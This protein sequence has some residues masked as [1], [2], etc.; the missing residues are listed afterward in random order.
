MNLT[1]EEILKVKS[2]GTLN[3]IEG[4]PLHKAVI[5]AMRYYAKQEV[6]AGQHE[7]IVKRPT[8]IKDR[9]GRMIYFG[10]T[11]RFVDKVE[12]YR[13]DYWAKVAHGVMTREEAL[14]EIDEKPYEER[15]VE[16]VQDYDWLLSSEIQT[17][18]EVVGA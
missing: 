2:K 14:K 6:E 8:D 11:V 1:P 7:T 3:I 16:N 12:W 13:G 18:W 17:Y 10:D 9:N 15:L 4:S 5:S